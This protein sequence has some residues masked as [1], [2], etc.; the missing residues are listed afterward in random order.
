MQPALPD[1]NKLVCAAARKEVPVLA[2]AEPVGG[3]G[4]TFKRV[5]KATLTQ[6]PQLDSSILRAGGQIV[7]RL[8]NAW[9][10]Y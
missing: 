4:M 8:Q 3:A 6:I 1:H 7:A 10:I 2:E 9:E 5:Q